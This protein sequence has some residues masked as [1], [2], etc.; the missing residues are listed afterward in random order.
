[1]EA[2]S[3]DIPPNRTMIIGVTGFYSLIG[4]QYQFY[5]TGCAVGIALYTIDADS[6]ILP[7]ISLQY[8]F[9]DNSCNSKRSLD[10]FVTL[11]VPAV[12][13]T[14]YSVSDEQLGVWLQPRT[15]Q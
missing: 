11:K 1:M 2:K 4:R 15:Y 9:G 3:E 8:V 5:K 10:I 13:G 6:L 14:A 7:N 12:V